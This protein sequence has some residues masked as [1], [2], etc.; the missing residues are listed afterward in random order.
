MMMAMDL[1]KIGD[2]DDTDASASP[3]GQD[4]PNDGIDQTVT[5]MISLMRIF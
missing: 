5:E 2:C 1:V 3:S 4:I